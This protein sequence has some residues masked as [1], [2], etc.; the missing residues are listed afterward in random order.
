MAAL[1][2]TTCL[3]SA[4]GCQTLAMATFKRP[5]ITF[6][7]IEVYSIG[8]GGASFD[9]LIDVYNP[10]SFGFGLDRVTYDLTLESVRLG[11]GETTSP[12]AVDA[13]S[14]GTLRIP[15][16][17]D[18]TRLSGLGTEVLRDGTVGYGVTGEVT[19]SAKNR[20]F[21]VPYDRTG[22]FSVFGKDRRL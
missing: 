9:L 2:A 13:Q 5:E 10:N 4:V 15:L 1:V 18:L 14:T 11:R 22:R 12:L 6:R 19:V 21:Q 20:T 8:L 7:G 16:T 17:L 3:L